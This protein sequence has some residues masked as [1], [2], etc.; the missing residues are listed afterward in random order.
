MTKTFSPAEVKATTQ[1]VNKALLPYNLAYHPTLPFREISAILVENG[2]D[3]ASF[4]IDGDEGRLN[5]HVGQDVWL[6]MTWYRMESGRYE[7]V[8]YAT[9]QYDDYREPYTTMMDTAERRKAKDKLNKTLA[10]ATRTYFKSKSVA[11][12]QIL[13]LIQQAGLDGNEFEDVTSSSA[14]IPG[15]GRVTADIGNRLHV[16]VTWYR[17]DSGN[18]EIVAYAH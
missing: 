8:V 18:Y 2:L 1:K 16:T 15:S 11:F 13:T 6:T 3:P 9:S 5:A 10:A 7:C 4:Q 17:M 14:T 12:H